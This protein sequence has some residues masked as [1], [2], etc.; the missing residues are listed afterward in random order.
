[1]KAFISYSHKDEEA[2]ERL[3]TH[4]AVLQREK[5]INAW[6]DREILAGD[7][8]DE[9]IKKELCEC[10]LFIPLVSPDFLASSYCYDT[11][12]SSAME[13]HAKGEIR[14]VPVIV[15]PCEWLETPLRDYKA[16]PKDGKAISEWKNENT[17]YLD[18]VTELRRTLADDSSTAEPSNSDDESAEAKPKQSRR[19]RVKKDFDAI[20]KAD[21]KEQS[22]E[23]LRTR[24]TDFIA[25][26]NDVDEIR[27]RFK[28]MG[29]NSFTCT[30]LNKRKSNGVAHITVHSVSEGYGFGDISYSFDENAPSNTSNGSFNI[31]SDDYELFFSSYHMGMRGEGGKMSAQQLAENLWEIFLDQAGVSYA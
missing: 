23:L 20:D 11:E 13:R 6:Y 4:L 14:V 12:M 18:V 15:E 16:V 19:Y 29:P 9:V 1:M 26:I 24:F 27:A 30:I 25:E 7:V 8:L 2:L 31:D 17:A 21:F 10:E 22:F 5:L 3:H 28:S